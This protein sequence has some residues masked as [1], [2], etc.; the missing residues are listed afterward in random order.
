[1]ISFWYLIIGLIVSLFVVTNTTI[2][3]RPMNKLYNTM[4]TVFAWPVF[5]FNMLI[6]YFYNK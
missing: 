2:N 3:D 6:D 4:V 5:V 1:M